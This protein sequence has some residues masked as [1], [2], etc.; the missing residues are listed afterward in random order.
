MTATTEPLHL[1]PAPLP[2]RLGFA[3]RDE[4]AIWPLQEIRSDSG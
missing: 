4:G 1:A 2:G 3:R